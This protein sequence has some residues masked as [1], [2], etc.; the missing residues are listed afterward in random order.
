M[1]KVMAVLFLALCVVSFGFAGGAEDANAGK[2]VV[3]LG[4][5][6]EDTLPGEIVM[7]EEFVKQFNAL[8]PDV[9]IEPAQYRY[10]ID[11]FVSLVESGQLPTIYE[12]WFTEPQ[13]HIDNGM[14]K[15]ITNELNSLGWTAKMN[16]SVLNI[17]SRNGRVYGVPRDGY[18]L[19][20]MLNVELFRQAGLVDRDG[21]P[22][23]PKTWQELAQTAK[24]IKDKTGMPGFLLCAKD[25]N[26]GWHFSNIA[27]AFGA[28]L[29]EQINGK[30]MSQLNTPEVVAAMEFVKSLKWEYDVLTPEPTNEDWAS[31]FVAIGT[32]T[33][34]MYMAAADAVNQPTM[35]NGLPVTDLAIAP[36]P[37][38]P[39]GQYSLMGGTPYEFAP[40]AT[41]EEVMG[42]L[43]YLEIM[44]RAPVVDAR[45]IA[46]LEADAAMRRTNGVPVLPSFPVWSDPAYIKAQMDSV[47]KYSNVDFRLYADYYTMVADESNLRTEEPMLTQDMYAELTK[48]IQECVTSRNANVKAL[49]DTAD[50][51][52]QALLDASVN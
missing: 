19:G 1:K 21:I 37:A 50:A 43:H 30:W 8:Y 45:T 46:G 27:W 49:L 17:L 33:A 5:W 6:P 31:G 13:K 9:V 29:Q 32:G 2:T 11:T 15:D 42:A 20:L 23:Y 38:G 52:F 41:S 40:D 48:V 14:V 35:V 51:N 18:A 36:M 7:H 24:V 44:G 28:D 4:M 39:G 10:A 26:G 3:E 22:L 16:P 12:G 47:N 25:N 34:A